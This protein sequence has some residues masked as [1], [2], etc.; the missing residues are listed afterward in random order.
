[1]AGNEQLWSARARH[2]SQVLNRQV[3]R[4]RLVAPRAHT[5]EELL[6]VGIKTSTKVQTPVAHFGGSPV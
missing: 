5:N 4:R 2:L 1:M 3:S 6:L